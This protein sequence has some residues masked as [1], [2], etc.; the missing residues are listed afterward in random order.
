MSWD[1]WHLDS[2]MQHLILIAHCVVSFQ[3][4]I[5]IPANDFCNMYSESKVPAEDGLYHTDLSLKRHCR[6]Q[7]FNF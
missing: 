7:V 5:L 3:L 2:Q 6:D 1:C 4:E